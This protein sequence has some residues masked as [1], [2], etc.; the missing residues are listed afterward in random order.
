MLAFFGYT[1]KRARQENDLKYYLYI[2]PI[3]SNSVYEFVWKECK[4]IRYH[5]T[6]K[7]SVKSILKNSLRLRDTNSGIRHRAIS[8]K[9]YLYCKPNY[10]KLNKNDLEFAHRVTDKESV[11]RNGL[12]C[13]RVDLN[14]C[15]G[16]PLYKDTMMEAN[17]VFICTSIPPGCYKEIS[18]QKI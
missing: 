9:I 1:A 18:L 13:I 17:A 7:G 5:F 8:K 12:A 6:D 14:R 4:G 10:A 11:K 16:I 3:Y 2:E 15:R